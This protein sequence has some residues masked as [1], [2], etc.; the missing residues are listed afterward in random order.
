MRSGLRGRVSYVSELDEA[1]LAEV[2]DGPV[3][4]LDGEDELHEAHLLRSHVIHRRQPI[5]DLHPSA[6]FLDSEIDRDLKTFCE[7]WSF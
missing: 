5:E 3:R 2:R 6:L 1:E 4:G 7:F